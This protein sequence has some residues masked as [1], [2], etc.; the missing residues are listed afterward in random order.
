MR[1]DSSI[2]LGD[3]FSAGPRSK[4]DGSDLRHSIGERRDLILALEHEASN[5]SLAGRGNPL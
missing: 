2:A 5:S 4:D 3:H 1:P